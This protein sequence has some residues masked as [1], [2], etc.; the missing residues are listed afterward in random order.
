MDLETARRREAEYSAKLEAELEKQEGERR[1]D[2]VSFWREQ[3]TFLRP[4]LTSA[5]A[6]G[7]FLPH[8]RTC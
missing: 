6:E 7:A 8:A 4:I 2:L 1:A 5:S 3:L